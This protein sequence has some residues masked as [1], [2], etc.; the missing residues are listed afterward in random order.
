MCLRQRGERERERDRE[1]EI[2]IS[3]IYVAIFGSLPLKVIFFYSSGK[4][5]RRPLCYAAPLPLKVIF[6]SKLQSVE[7]FLEGKRKKVGKRLNSQNVCHFTK[8]F[9]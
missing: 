5:E 7:S 3:D 8:S 2:V 9:L 4:P 1:R 6:G